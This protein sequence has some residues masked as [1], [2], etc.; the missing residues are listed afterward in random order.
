MRA[1]GAVVAIGQATGIIRTRLPAQPLFR[2]FGEEAG[3]LLGGIAMTESTGWEMHP[4]GDE[5]LT[6]LTGRVDIVID[7]ATGA[8]TF[9]LEPMRSCVVPAGAWHR[10]IIHEPSELLFL[11]PALQTQHRRLDARPS[12]NEGAYHV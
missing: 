1:V 8:R 12:A 4:D 5:A 11:T 3:V 9:A 10:M 2:R 7:D 6:L